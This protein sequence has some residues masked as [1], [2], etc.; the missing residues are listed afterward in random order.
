MRRRTCASAN[1]F[2]RWSATRMSRRRDE[3]DPAPVYLSSVGGEYVLDQEH[4]F[5]QAAR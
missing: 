2:L 3:P 1:K 4:K 5:V